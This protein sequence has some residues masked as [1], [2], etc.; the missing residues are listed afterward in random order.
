MVKN[1]NKQAKTLAGQ[2]WTIADKNIIVLRLLILQKPLG[3]MLPLF[4]EVPPFTK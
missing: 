3:E 2:Q 4:S 1:K